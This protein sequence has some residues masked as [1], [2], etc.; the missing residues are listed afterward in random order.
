MAYRLLFD[1]IKKYRVSLSELENI[2]PG[3]FWM[4][5]FASDG[6]W[7]NPHPPKKIK[8]LSPERQPF[9]TCIFPAKDHGL[10][11][12]SQAGVY[13]ETSLLSREEPQDVS[14]HNRQRVCGQQ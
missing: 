11:C 9:F 3:E 6:V 4:K 5:R 12:T 2:V 1:T 13:S 14:L 7:G 8:K 10:S